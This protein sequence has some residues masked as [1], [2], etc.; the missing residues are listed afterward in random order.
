[1]Y[2][3]VSS[4]FKILGLKLLVSHDYVTGRPLVVQESMW[5]RGRSG[6]LWSVGCVCVGRGKLP[7]LGLEAE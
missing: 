2:T 5:T 6:D 7:S 1:M 4:K 3:H